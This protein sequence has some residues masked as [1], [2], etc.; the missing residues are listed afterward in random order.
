MRRFVFISL[1]GLILSCDTE[2]NIP[3]PED[4]CFLKF[5][6]VEGEQTGVDFVQTP[7][8]AIVMVG[9]ST[10]PGRTQMIYVVKVDLLG[11]VIWENMIGLDDKNNAVKDIE[12]HPDGR[13]VIA[14]ETEIAVGNRDVF[15]KTMSS[16]G[17]ELDSVRYGVTAT[18]DE[19]VN[20]VSIFGSGINTIENSFVV[21]G[22]TNYVIDPNPDPRDTKDGLRVR[23]IEEPT[24]QPTP[25]AWV[26]TTGKN[27]S[28]DV[29]VKVIQ[30]DDNMIY[31]FGYTNAIRNGSG[32]FKY[33][34]APLDDAGGP[35]GDDEALLIALGSVSEDEILKSVIDININNP[36]ESGFLL[37][38]VA[39][40]NAGNCRSYVVKLGRDL[41]FSVD[42][43]LYP[44]P[45][46]SHPNADLRINGFYSPL[47]SDFLILATQNVNSN[48]ANDLSLF[49]LDR[50]Y[51][52]EWGPQVF[53]GESFDEAGAVLQLA[54]G[55]IMVLGTMTVG[56]LSGQKKMALMKLNSEGKLLR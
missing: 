13:L 28:E 25:S 35:N 20:S 55:K 10:Q 18:S 5:Y 22:A 3:L 42:D 41:P 48:L 43:Q 49:K 56:G 45:L 19:E 53:G 52:L 34:V 46:G 14:G 50:E 7:D 51:Q 36:F 2:R 47:N 32:D 26:E 54:D 17:V 11:N 38:G 31:S 40:N 23:F 29:I 33:W 16:D 6:G 15:L 24:L 39:R 8:N 27:E 44:T 1:I 4:C 30:I 9:N 12:L 21:A 37:A